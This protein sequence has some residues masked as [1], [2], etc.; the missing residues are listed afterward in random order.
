MNTHALNR[1]SWY[2]LDCAVI[3]AL[4]ILFGYFFLSSHAFGAWGDDSPGYI[5]TAGRIIRGEP[6]VMQDTLV[7]DALAFFGEER[8]A[9]FVAPAHHEII[10]PEGWIAS[11]YPIGLSVLMALISRSVQRETTM[12][13]VVPLAAV[14]TVLLTY[15]LAM[16]TLPL[17]SLLKRLAAFMAAVSVGVA[18][19]F[20]NYAVAQPMREIP[21]TAF[22]LLSVIAVL[23][24]RRQTTTWLAYTALIIGG[25][26]FGY[27]V[28][29][30][31]TNAVLLI[32]LLIALW[33]KKS[34]DVD[35]QQKLWRND[36]F[37][38][39]AAFG[40]AVVVALSMSI[41][42]STQITVH[43]EKFRSKDISRIAITSNFEHIQSLH[44]KNLFN[45]QGKFKPGVGG[46]QQYW[47][48]MKGFSIWQP[49]L[50]LAAFGCFMLWQK[51]RRLASA[52]ATWFALV[53][54]LFAMWINP[55]PRYILP[56]LPPLAVM[57]AF[58][59]IVV[60]EYLCRWL[61]C[62]VNVRRIVMALVLVSFFFT[63]KKAFAELNDR[64]ETREPVYK[65]I[66]QDDL[67]LLKQIPTV[68]TTNS[69]NTREPLLLM[70]G[71]Y[72]GGL[73]ETMMAHTDLRVIRFPSKPNEQPPLFELEKFL[74][75]RE[76]TYSL[77]IWYDPTASAA[78]QRFLNQISL[79]DPLA[80][81]TFSFQ[82]NVTLYA[83]STEN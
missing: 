61:Q 39:I 71:A 49:F 30:R 47:Q 22:F 32:P 18:D 23:C 31:E 38:R 15:V 34:N 58:G 65:S 8:F 43:K 19:V 42:N 26:F 35:S 83:I 14:A 81:F 2:A 73:A 82:P 5:Y 46:L 77:F 44:P 21:A 37:K 78:E 68:L 28:N 36:Q 20:A 60:A 75:Q 50:A 25:L 7:Q 67:R 12:Y 62:G 76:E 3:V 24:V 40:L 53:Y 52:Y 41:W 79:S 59:A 13:V 10:S 57:S 27:S 70:F 33:P 17:S 1:W 48:V 4:G 80:T 16:T 64:V 45:N 9:R 6:L 54:V 51:N 56:L 66:T 63:Q 72:K 11:R 29:I 55:Y 74:H 69:A